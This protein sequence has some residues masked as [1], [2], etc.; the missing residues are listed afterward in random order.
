MVQ[1]TRSGLVA[2]GPA[3]HVE[4]LRAQFEERSCVRLPALIEPGL[5]AFIQQQIDL[6]DFA[7]QGHEGVGRETAMIQNVTFSLL[8]F[9]TN[10]THLFELVR[11]ITGCARIGCFIGRVY[12]LIPGLGHAADWH[13]DT[14][15]CR[16]IGMSVNLSTDIYQGGTFHLRKVGSTAPLCEIANTGAG[17]AILFRIAKDLEHQV[18]AV[19]GTTPKTA[20]AGWFRSQPEFLSL[21]AARP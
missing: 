5:L 16:M 14:F 18:T 7:P 8:H 3:A 6:A 10:D 9:L 17:D 20:F 2:S 1:L 15:E 19:E 21:I 11:Q 13:S 4:R 12:R